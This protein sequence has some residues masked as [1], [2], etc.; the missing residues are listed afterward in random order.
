MFPIAPTPLRL[1]AGTRSFRQAS[2]PRLIA[3]QERRIT[4]AGP[5]ANPAQSFDIAANDRAERQRRDRAERGDPHLVGGQEEDVAGFV[6]QPALRQ[7][8]PSEKVQASQ[9]G[10]TAL[11]GRSLILAD[12]AYRRVS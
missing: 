3:S 1:S 11:P 5:R 9:L 7:C 4:L 12:R 8:S 6:E 10:Q 2:P